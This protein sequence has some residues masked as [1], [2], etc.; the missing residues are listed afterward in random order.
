MSQ[1][2]SLV[3]NFREGPARGRQNGAM[4]TGIDAVAWPVRTQRL[5]LR[6]A[7][8]ADAGPT[9]RFRQ[10]AEVTEWITAA[11][12]GLEEYRARFEGPERLSKTLVIERTGHVIGDLMLSVEDAWS[13]AEVA[14]Q[15]KGVQAEL[16]WCIDPAHAGRGYATEAVQELIRICFDELG[17]RR[18]TA[19]CFADNVGSWRLMERVG[20]RRETYTV[21]ESLHRSGTWLDGMGYALLVDEWRQRLDGAAI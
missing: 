6:P 5:L 9:W 21:A 17:L 12:K 10:L 19:S 4:A 11:P 15:A 1:R 16:G 14:E 13:Q 8:A 2:L 7:V 3:D 18:V 20:M